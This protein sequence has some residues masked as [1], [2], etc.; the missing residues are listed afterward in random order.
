[1]NCWMPIWGAC[2]STSERRVA[3]RLSYRMQ[4]KQGGVWGDKC[5]PRLRLCEVVARLRGAAYA[6]ATNVGY[7]AAGIERIYGMLRSAGH[8]LEYAKRRLVRSQIASSSKASSASWLWRLRTSSCRFV[9]TRSGF[10][11]SRR[12]TRSCR[13]RS[14]PSTVVLHPHA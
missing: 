10:C 7:H 14:M 3:C 6:K 4:R 11:T 2:P 9:P 5:D 13:R 1:M 8:R 12:D